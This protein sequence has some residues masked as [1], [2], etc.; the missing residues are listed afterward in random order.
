MIYGGSFI[1]VSLLFLSVFVFLRGRE[2][3]FGRLD[4]VESQASTA[5]SSIR[6][7]DVDDSMKKLLKPFRERL[8]SQDSDTKNKRANMMVMAGYYNPMAFTIL[9]A[10][11]LILAVVLAGSAAFA[12]A[13]GGANYGP[14]I[15][16]LTIIGLATIGYFLP[17]LIVKSKISER[18]LKFQQAL[19]D[20]MDMLLVSLEA[21]LSFPASLRHVSKEMQ[22]VH[23]VL[24]EQFQMVTLEFQA[25]RQR[26]EALKN[27]ADRVDLQEVYSMTTMII[28][29]EELGTSLTAALRATSEDMRRDRMFKAEEKA[30]ALPVKMSVPLVLCIFPTLFA[31]I[32]V[33]VI[34]KI[35]RVL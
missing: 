27:L 8:A 17:I 29:S 11:R 10:A 15:I 20:A 32:L 14:T 28:Q 16:I 18:K 13:V 1:T 7:S 24:S 6:K 19:P 34:V 4:L 33:P 12:F 2:N 9:Y 21:G 35:T 26:A 25:G 22:A 3:A 5:P 31:I 30:N 23:P